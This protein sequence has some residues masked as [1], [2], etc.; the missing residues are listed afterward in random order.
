[1]DIKIKYDGKWP[2]LCGGHLEVWI[3]GVY[4]DFGKHCLSSGGC[5]TG[6]PPD[7]DFEIETGP[8]EIYDWPEGFPEDKYLR[9]NVLEEINSTV[10]HGCC[11]GCI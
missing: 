7:W 10:S 2:C 4:W 11:G 9:L 8:W 1:M 6:G 3:D 5:V